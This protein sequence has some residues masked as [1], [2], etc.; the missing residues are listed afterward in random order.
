MRNWLAALFLVL[1]TSLAFSQRLPETAVPE[2]YQLFLAPNFDKDN[3][4]GDETIRVR[5]LKPTD[6]I[7]LNAAEIKFGDASIS[8]NSSSQPAKVT[9]DAK[10]ETATLTV[11][12]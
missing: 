6:A 11:A 4:S 12:N 1:L 3:F 10:Q 7:T 2:N 5:L 8:Q 9:T